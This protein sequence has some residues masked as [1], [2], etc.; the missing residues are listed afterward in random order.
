[1]QINEI[2][3]GQ[4][5]TVKQTTEIYT[6]FTEPALR[7][8]LFNKHT[9]GLAKYVRKVGRKILIDLEGFAEWIESQQEVKHG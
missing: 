9:N 8:H 7:A 3:K 2:K 6:C 4:Y 1:M 5:A